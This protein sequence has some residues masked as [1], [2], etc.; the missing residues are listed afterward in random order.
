MVPTNLGLYGPLQAGASLP[1]RR[2]RPRMLGVP[3]QVHGG[4]GFGV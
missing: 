2:D 1:P 4:L 3:L